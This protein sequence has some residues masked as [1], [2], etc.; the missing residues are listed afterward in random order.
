MAQCSVIGVSVAATPLCSAIIFCKDFSP[1]RSDREVAR[2]V[3]QG[4]F[5][6]GVGDVTSCSATAL[7]HLLNWWEFA[8]TLCARLCVARQGSQQWCDT[9]LYLRD[10]ETTIKIKCAFLTEAGASGAERKIVSNPCFSENA[11]TTKS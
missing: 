11:M 4:L 2:W 8:V 9:K 3:R 7:R 6:R 1:R 10:G 5:C